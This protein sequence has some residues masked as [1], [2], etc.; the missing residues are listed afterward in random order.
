MKGKVS[1]RSLGGSFQGHFQLLGIIFLVL[2]VLLACA[3]IF[4]LTLR[5]V[6]ET[7]LFDTDEAA[8]ATPALELYVA[9]QRRD[10][11]HFSRA[12]FQQS[13]Y[14]PVHSLTVLPSY[15]IAG[16]S[17]ATTRMPTVVTFAV[18]L[19]TVAVFTYRIT[20]QIAEA[21]SG[22]AYVATA[23]T[24]YFVS[25]SPVLI[26]N[27]VLSMLELIGCLWVVLLLWLCWR[28]DHSSSGRWARA[29]SLALMLLVIT[30][31]KYSFGAIAIPAIVTAILTGSKPRTGRRSQ[32]IEAKAVLVVLAVGLGFWFMV[33]GFQGALR[34]AFNQP[35]YAR[36]LSA[37]NLFYYPLAWLNEFHLHPILGFSTALLA[38]WGAIKGWNH[39]AVRTASWVVFFSLLMLTISLNNQPRHF[40]I[41]GPCIWFLAAFGLAQLLVMLV[42]A[43]RSR[44]VQ[45]VS[46]IV[47]FAFLGIV[48]FQ[49]AEELQ[50]QL[51]YAFEGQDG[52]RI[53]AM[54]SYVLDN[55]DLEGR[56]LILGLF[57]QF[58]AMAIRWQGAITT[59]R[60]PSEI[61]VA[62]GP[63]SDLEPNRMPSDDE[64][65]DVHE[66][67]VLKAAATQ[68]D[69][70]QIVVIYGKNSTDPYVVAAPSALRDFESTSRLFGDYRIDIFDFRDE[71]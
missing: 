56:I 32:L 24:V 14:P 68:G 8:H 42:K 48:A 61:S 50:P 10:I 43:G 3:I 34:F 2:A 18:L 7:T 39:L 1:N 66:A 5:V 23:A 12:I 29:C 70:N 13:F 60:A 6:G 55:V 64:G 65:G 67:V 41:A 19:I 37:K 22:A 38:C 30:L 31:T 17:L 11:A 36:L 44:L 57:D 25:T 63:Q 15:L 46:L 28:L 58:N 27:A 16:P 52:D 49:R 62:T 35:Q 21:D 9:V 33:A 71:R 53:E 20:S 40:A 45:S 54:Q 59:G 26:R 51:T 47:M 4:E 69:Y